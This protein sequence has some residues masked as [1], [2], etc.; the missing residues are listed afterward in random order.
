MLNE[1]VSLSPENGFEQVKKFILNNRHNH[2][3]TL[4]YLILKRNLRNG[5][6]SKFDICSPNFNPENLQDQAEALK[7]KSKSNEDLEEIE[8][9]RMTTATGPRTFR[10]LTRGVSN[11]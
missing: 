1:V 8:L 7:A 4:Y 10:A 6:C 9:D 11:R 2:S 5:I 3:I